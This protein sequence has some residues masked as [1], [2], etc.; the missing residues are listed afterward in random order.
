MAAFLAT[1]TVAHTMLTLTCPWK[2]VLYSIIDSAPWSRLNDTIVSRSTVSSFRRLTRTMYKSSR[3]G[4]VR[5]HWKC[6]PSTMRSSKA[7][8][9][10]FRPCN[11]LPTPVWPATQDRQLYQVHNAIS[12]PVSDDYFWMSDCVR[13]L[14]SFNYVS[15]AVMYLGN[16]LTLSMRLSPFGKIQVRQAEDLTLPTSVGPRWKRRSCSGCFLC[17]YHQRTLC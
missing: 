14:C 7:P 11:A 1:T 17:W 16:R 6:S 13:C 12:N 9:L 8:A 5:R 2:R 4:L 15:R 3:L 10:S